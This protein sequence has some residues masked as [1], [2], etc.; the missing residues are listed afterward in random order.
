MVDEALDEVEAARPGEAA[1]GELVEGAVAAEAGEVGGVV[2]EDVG[3]LFWVGLGLYGGFGGKEGGK[4]VRE[5][6]ETG[7]REAASRDSAE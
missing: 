5:G 7:E 3:E 6:G 2:V 4:W 1:A